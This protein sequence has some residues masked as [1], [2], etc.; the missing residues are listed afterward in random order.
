MRSRWLRTLSFVLI[1]LL[2][3]VSSQAQYT[4]ITNGTAAPSGGKTGNIYIR[5]G[6]TLPGFYIN[7]S[8]WIG[9]FNTPI[10]NVTTSATLTAGKVIVGNGTTDITLATQ[11]GLAL[12]ASGALSAY[13]GTSCTNQFPRSLNASGAAT[14]ASVSLTADV[15]GNLPVTNLNSGTSASN[16]TF[17]RGDATWATPTAGSGTVTNTGTLTANRLMLGNGGVD[18]TALG[19]LGTTVTLLHGNAA[20]APTFGAVSLTAD[21]T[22]NLPVTNLNSGTSASNTTFWRGDATWAMPSGSGNVTTGVTLTANKLV[23]GNGSSDIIVA[24]ATNGQIPIGKTSDGTVTLGTITQGLGTTI[25]N[26]AATVT[27]SA[28]GVIPYSTLSATVATG[29][30]QI[31]ADN[32]IPQNTEGD[33]LMTL[34]MTPAS[35][36]STLD[37]LIVAS[38]ASDTTAR[39]FTCALFQDSG[40]NALAAAG[41]AV[42]GANSS[43]QVTL[44]FTMAAGT[45]SSTTF[46][47]RC[48]LSG[49]GTYTFN[50]SGG[51]QRYST[52]PKSAIILK[53]YLP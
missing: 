41:V 20:G 40:A 33:Q 37:F 45:T 24:T 15:T 34:T 3:A 21:V 27:V 36:S 28:K 22:G 46:N 19:S 53:E 31:P 6:G 38:A 2:P 32:T 47:V 39:V 42:P 25:T 30:T 17:W 48:G 12:L 8:G 9:P 51:T 26:G 18:I 13:G 16:T 14:C 49:T 52:N 29:S 11:T 44:P 10:G 5:S 23:L 7:I 50:G 1:F 43:T 4:S 35:A